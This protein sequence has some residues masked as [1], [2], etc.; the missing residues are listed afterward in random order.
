MACATSAYTSNS[1]NTAA[2]HVTYA[3]K[4]PSKGQIQNLLTFED[5]LP[6]MRRLVFCDDCICTNK[7]CID[8]GVLQ[9][10]D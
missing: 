8:F 10:I 3:A 4:R 2:E 6:S 1:G 7:L 5:V 9:N